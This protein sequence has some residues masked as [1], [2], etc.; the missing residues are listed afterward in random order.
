MRLF[1]L[2]SLTMIAFAANSVLNRLAL[3]DGLIGASSFA[4]V[5][6]LSGAVMLAALVWWRDRKVFD[7]AEVSLLSVLGLSS[8]VLGFAYAYQSLDAGV[9]ALIL[10][11]VVQI[12]MFVGAMLKG[13]PPRLNQWIG[14]GVA[15]AGLAYLL[16]PS[17][18]APP[19]DGAILMAVAGLGWGYYSLYGRGVT[20]PLQATAGNFLLSLPFAL[21]AW[22]LLP[23]G[24]VATGAGVALAVVS[25]A[26]TSGLGYALWY[27]VLPRLEAAQAAIA[28]LAVPLIALLGGVA[29]L[30][31]GLS[32]AFAVASVLILG[33]VVISMRRKR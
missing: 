11:G 23:D 10:F 20:R 15:F 33:G 19:L 17:A 2:T 27:A 3:A 24:G 25:G 7:L 16:A 12:T 4:F 6:V 32:V 28:Q 14:A 22:F 21:A 30:G 9:G 1:L 13:E 18:T 31:E 29:F 8:Y 5:R 26:V